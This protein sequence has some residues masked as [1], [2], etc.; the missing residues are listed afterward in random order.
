MDDLART[1]GAPFRRIAFPNEQRFD[2]EGFKGRAMSASYSP[3]PLSPAHEPFMSGL[4]ALF[5]ANQRE[6]KIVFE[7]ETEV[8]F[9]RMT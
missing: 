8:F 1:F 2:F 9:G 3:Q 4:R 5:D 7:Y 6:G